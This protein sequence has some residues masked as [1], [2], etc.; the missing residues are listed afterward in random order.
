MVLDC[1]PAVAVVHLRAGGV[2]GLYLDFGRRVVGDAFVGGA[3]VSGLGRG[4]KAE[5]EESRLE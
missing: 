3:G 4:C 1:V 2:L 5:R